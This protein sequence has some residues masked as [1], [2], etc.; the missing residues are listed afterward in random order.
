LGVLFQ[1]PKWEWAER[2]GDSVVWAE[3]GCL[4][5]ATTTAHG[6][7]DARLLYDA[8]GLEF[9]RIQAPY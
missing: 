8:N 2:D 9:E 4:Y 1:K 3:A 7:E 6:L 5:R